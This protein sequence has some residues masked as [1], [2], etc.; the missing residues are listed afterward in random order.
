MGWRA[1]F[2]S[3]DAARNRQ[4]REEARR[5]RLIEKAE[6]RAQRSM[7]AIDAEFE[8]ELERARKFEVILTEDPVSRGGLDF[9]RPD[10]WLLPPLADNT[11]KIRYSVQPVVQAD[12]L[13]WHPACVHFEKRSF[14]LLSVCVSVYGVY[15]AFAVGPSTTAAGA[16][17]TKLLS[18]KNPESGLLAIKCGTELHFPIDGNLD[19]RVVEGAVR[20]AV[21]A[22]EPFD[23]PVGAFEVLFLPRTESDDE[24]PLAIAVDGDFGAISDRLRRTPSFCEQFQDEVERAR[25]GCERQVAEDLAEVKYGCRR[26]GCF[27]LLVFGALALG[28]LRSDDPGSGNWKRPGPTAGRRVE[29][30]VASPAGSSPVDRV[31]NGMTEQDVLT[32]CGLP[33]RVE[34]VGTQRLFRYSGFSVL[35]DKAGRVVGVIKAPAEARPPPRSAVP[36]KTR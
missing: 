12:P 14:E 28:V 18:K 33:V 1:A 7:N 16:R 17:Q 20:V 19:G 34:A 35:L 21:V 11:G 3:V 8:K 5:R 10:R 36:P 9:A 24:S 27:A 30:P 29:S 15:L 23:E 2:R 31:T 22:F 25:A 26:P 13:Q 32:Q 4:A 6:A